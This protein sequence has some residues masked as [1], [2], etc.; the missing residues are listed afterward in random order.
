MALTAEILKQQEPLKGLTDDQLTVIATL[1][2]NDEDSSISQKMGSVLG[3]IDAVILELTGKSKPHGVKTVDFVKSELSTLKA[4]GDNSELKNQLKTLKS[5][6][7]A[8]EAK[9]AI[10]SGDEAL[11]TKVSEL[12]QQ[13]TDKTNSIAE[14]QTKLEADKS[15][16][17]KQIEAEKANLVGLKIDN[18]FSSALT[19][20]KFK[21]EEIIPK[22]VRE[23][24]ISNAK[25]SL[26]SEYKP[27]W[28]DNGQGGKRMVF[29]NK[30][31]VIV[32]NPNNSLQP[33]TASE[34]LQTK[35]KDILDTGHKAGGTGTKPTGGTGTTGG[36]VITGAKTKVEAT[37]LIEQSLAAQGIARN[38]PEYQSKLTQAY[39][40]NKVSELPLTA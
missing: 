29:R 39:K 36:V 2:K 17:Q 26:L 16:Y 34:L 1:S 8:L 32:N 37:K 7:E 3:G 13:L 27:D 25:S 6:K 4:S 11:K 30:E 18:E 19:G 20:M 35:V 9:I 5:E 28:I 38:H 22:A 24:F 23:S 12:Q 31:G 10:G 14:L 15:E 21:S 33:F 40:D